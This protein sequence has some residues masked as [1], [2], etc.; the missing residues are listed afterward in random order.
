LFAAQDRQHAFLEPEH[1]LQAL[2]EDEDARAALTGCG[3]DLG[4]LRREVAAHLDQLP[5]VAKSEPGQ[6]P[7]TS[8]A[9]QQ[10]VQ[11]AVTRMQL[12]GRSTTTGADVLLSLTSHPDWP[13]AG[14]L[15]SQGLDDAKIQAFLDRGQAKPSE[16][17]NL[18]SEGRQRGVGR[19]IGG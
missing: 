6:F 16:A 17:E 1:L 13:T 15:G 2:I 9:L 8:M 14:I 5:T 18:S 11:E 10:A 12:A 19:C 7:K 3:A 4:Q